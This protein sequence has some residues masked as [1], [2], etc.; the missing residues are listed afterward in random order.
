MPRTKLQNTVDRLNAEEKAEEA[1]KAEEAAQIAANMA[2]LEDNQVAMAEGKAAL[3]LEMAEADRRAAE[4]NRKRRQQRAGIIET[5]IET[6]TSAPLAT[7]LDLDADLDAPPSDEPPCLDPV[8]TAS[9]TMTIPPHDPDDP[10]DGWQV[11]DVTVDLYF[12]HNGY[13]LV[14]VGP[15]GTREEFPP[16]ETRDGWAGVAA[17][18]GIKIAD[19]A[20]WAAF[21]ALQLEHPIKECRRLAQLKWITQVSKATKEAMGERGPR[22]LY[23]D[24]NLLGELSTYSDGVSTWS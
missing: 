12:R 20:D 16:V 23:R 6:D 15:D 1:H 18:R 24:R 4:R 17:Y 2:W 14:V 21:N 11:H 9:A 7:P 22:E 8:W 3:E 10:R 19:D 13:V 5:D